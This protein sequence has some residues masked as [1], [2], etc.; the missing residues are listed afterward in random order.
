MC[1]ENFIMTEERARYILTF[2]LKDIVNCENEIEKR[3]LIDTLD[4]IL[5]VS[6][7]EKWDLS[8]DKK[9]VSL[10]IDT[11]SLEVLKI[12]I[13]NGAS[14]GQD[15]LLEALKKKKS[16]IIIAL[17]DG[18]VNL[19]DNTVSES[20]LLYVIENYNEEYYFLVEKLLQNGANPNV[21]DR[22]NNSI[23]LKIL[24]EHYFCKFPNTTMGLINLLTKYGA[25]V[26]FNNYELIDYTATYISDVHMFD[27]FINSSTAEGVDIYHVFSLAAISNN[28]NIMNYILSGKT[29]EF[30]KYIILNAFEC[31]ARNNYN[32]YN[33]IQSLFKCDISSDIFI[34]LLN[35]AKK[36]KAK[37]KIIKLIESAINFQKN[38]K[39]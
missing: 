36:I 5:R 12:F 33:F 10:A 1:K 38:I 26:S 21:L 15:E 31:L 24:K 2:C 35:R 28:I 20:P 11:D 13:N 37:R 4:E 6:E 7:Q 27:T 39:N 32:L 18:G 19:N 9:Y 34:K 23:L 14:F 25:D 30:K 17:I 8:L 3:F 22:K 16:N 29:E